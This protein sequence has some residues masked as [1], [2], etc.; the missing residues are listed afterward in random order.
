MEHTDGEKNKYV[1]VLFVERID[2]LEDNYIPIKAPAK[3]PSKR[4][5]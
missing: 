5:F 4:L 2:K 1:G 3:L